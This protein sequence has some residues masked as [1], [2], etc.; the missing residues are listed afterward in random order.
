MI[1]KKD[2]RIGNKNAGRKHVEDKKKPVQVYV[3][4]SEIDAIGGIEQAR[5]I[6][7]TALLNTANKI[8]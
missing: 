3:K 1:K 2:K 6:A 4:A 7:K 8:N 5:H